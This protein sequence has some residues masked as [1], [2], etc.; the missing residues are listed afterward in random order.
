MT[1]SRSS[2]A[3]L[4]PLNA[5]MKRNSLKSITPSLL[6]SDKSDKA[7]GRKYDIKMIECTKTDFLARSVLYEGQ[8]CFTASKNVFLSSSPV[9]YLAINSYYI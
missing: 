7:L 2:I 8:N 5:A 1:S 3:P 4:R 6:V 9:G